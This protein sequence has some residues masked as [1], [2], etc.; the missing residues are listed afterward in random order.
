M[1]EE[2]IMEYAM[3]SCVHGYHAYKDIWEAVVGERVISERESKN[4]MDRN[5]VAIKNNVKIL[6]LV[7]R[8]MS[9]ICSLFFEELDQY[10]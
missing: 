4:Q 9:K 7:P 5:A 1:M 2:R 3:D 6:G 8:K 10:Q